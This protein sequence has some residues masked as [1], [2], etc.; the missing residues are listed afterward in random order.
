MGSFP[1]GR[2]GTNGCHQKIMRKNQMPL[3]LLAAAGL[4]EEG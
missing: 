3:K 2:A 4:Q 1:P